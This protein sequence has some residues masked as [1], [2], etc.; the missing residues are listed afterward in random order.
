MYHF[1][2]KNNIVQPIYTIHVTAEYDLLL[3]VLWVLRYYVFVFMPRGSRPFSLD[4]SSSF[5]CL[6]I[7]TINYDLG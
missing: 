4:R 2:V 3:G 7:S 1:V 6:A 5:L